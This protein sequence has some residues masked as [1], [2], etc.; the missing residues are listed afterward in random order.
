[1]GL[2]KN[3]PRHEQNQIFLVII[4][5]VSTLILLCV[6]RMEN[7]KSHCC[8]GDRKVVYFQ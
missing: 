5:S 7:L 3:G 8:R 6:D 4:P 2:D 1:M